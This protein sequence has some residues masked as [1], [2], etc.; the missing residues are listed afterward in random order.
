[1]TLL[2]AINAVIAADDAFNPDEGGPSYELIAAATSECRAILGRRPNATG[3]LVDAAKSI[4]QWDDADVISECATW[5]VYDAAVE[6]C[7]SAVSAY[8]IPSIA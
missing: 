3:P 5:D 8:A 1:M 4:V 2:E 6:R 7:R